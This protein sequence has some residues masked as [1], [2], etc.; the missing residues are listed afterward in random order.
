[1]P[2]L[3][4]AISAYNYGYPL[5]YNLD[6]FSNQSAGKQ[7]LAA[8]SGE[9]GVFGHG[10]ALA[11]HEF[12]FVS[13]NN[14]TL[15]SVAVIDVRSGPIK[16]RVPATDRYYVLQFVDAWTNNFAYIGTRAT[17]NEA[18]EFLLVDSAY[19]GADAGAPGTI[20]APTGLFVIVGRIAVADASDLPAAQAF[21]DGLE[22]ELGDQAEFTGMPVPDP[23]TDPD[24]LFWERLRVSLAA[25]PPAPIELDVLESYRSLGILDQESPYITPDPKLKEMLLSGEKDGAE[26]IETLIKSANF[27]V[28]GW[29]A[30]THVFDYNLDHFELGTMDA[31]D[32]RFPDRTFAHMARSGAA[33]VGLWGNHGYEAVYAQV[34]LDENDEQL[35]GAHRYRL[36]LPQTPPVRAFWSLTMYDASKFYLVDNP[37]DRYSIGDRTLG[38][39]YEADG[40]LTIYLQFSEPEADQRSNWLPTPAGDFRPIMRMYMPTDAILDGSYQLPGIQCLD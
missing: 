20:K 10:R 27:A 23:N 40:S 18:G 35:S 13:P 33:R 31:D 39:Q 1:M 32:W 6:E 17:G 8:G 12:E 14:D 30:G 26:R 21:Q 5:L 37:I 19:S 4:L 22:L 3:E 38:L 7:G 2:D 25:F 16:L 34:F 29:T 11:T 24:L 36:H 28:N 15:Y 9:I